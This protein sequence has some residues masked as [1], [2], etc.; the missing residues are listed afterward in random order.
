Y[1]NLGLLAK[2]SL[3]YVSPGSG[4]TTATTTSTLYINYGYDALRRVRS[5]SNAVGTTSNSY[6]PWQLTITDPNSHTKDLIK[7]AY[8]NL[9]QVNEH[10]GAS[11]YVTTYA[12]DYLKDLTNV[13]DANGN[14]RNFTFDGLGR[15]LSAQDLHPSSSLTFGT[16]TY[17][18]DNGGNLTQKV[19]PDGNTVNYT[20]DVLN[21]PVLE[22]LGTVGK[23][24]YAYDTCTDGVGLLC[25]VTTPSLTTTDAYNAL[26]L[27]ATEIKNIN[28]TNYE[29]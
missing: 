26:G 27:L 15:R 8:D 22:K 17:A 6:S 18:Y 12:Y 1:S 16:W 24:T 28:A 19:D 3:P 13:T 20:Y 21:R 10:N 5:V 7:D 4:R 11:T 23:V 29:T 25:S 2:E 14:V 9:I